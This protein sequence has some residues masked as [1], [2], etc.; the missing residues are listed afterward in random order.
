MAPQLFAPL[1]PLVG[2]SLRFTCIPATTQNLSVSSGLSDC[3]AI[4]SDPG[5]LGYIHQLRVLAIQRQ[6]P[7]ASTDGHQGNRYQLR[8]GPLRLI[9][10]Q[11]T[12]LVIRSYIDQVRLRIDQ[13]QESSD[14]FS[15][16]LLP[17][18]CQIEEG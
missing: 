15:M 13:V 3:T 14:G 1:L 17:L 9:F 18:G 5:S 7:K 2:S 12:I 4:F 16:P 11:S 8:P 10:L 6:I